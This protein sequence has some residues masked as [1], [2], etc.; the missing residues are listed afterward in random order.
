MALTPPHEAV[1]VLDDLLRTW[2][3]ISPDSTLSRTAAYSLGALYR[4]GPMRL[5]ALAT[6]QAVSQPAMTGLVRR[7][8]KQG[9]VARS[10]DPSDGRVV[11][12]ALTQR[13]RAEVVKRQ[14]F[15]VRE[16]ESRLVNLDEAELSQLIAALPAL[17]HIT[18]K[19]S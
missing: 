7:L 5:T 14:D 19:E 10:S 17:R 1:E 18:A 9:L 12:V 2:R 4:T 8:E 16:I 15:Y 3:R 6:D 13:G 11:F